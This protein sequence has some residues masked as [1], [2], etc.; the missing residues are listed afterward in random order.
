MSHRG[1]KVRRIVLPKRLPA[2]RPAFS[3][4]GSKD[5]PEALRETHEQG[6]EKPIRK[7]SEAACGSDHGLHIGL[8]NDG[9]HGQDA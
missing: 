1:E 4:L 7:I 2:T 9:T 8:G 5:S 3:F 6:F